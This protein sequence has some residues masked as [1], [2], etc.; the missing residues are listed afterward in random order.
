M[1]GRRRVLTGG[2]ALTAAPVRGMAATLPPDPRFEV[3]RD[4]IR[5]GHPAISFH[6]DGDTTVAAVEVEIVVRLGPIPVFRYTHSVRETWHGD[7][8]LS[9]E[10]DTYNDGTPYHVEAAN[11][12][13]H[14]I[15]A[16]RTVPHAELPPE[17]IPLTHWNQLRMR[18]P[19]F[20]P[21]DGVPV[22][23]TV[24]P[25]GEE[26][27]AMADGRAVRAM[28]YSLVGKIA[29]EDWY[30]AAGKWIALRSI[31]HDGSRI[32]YRLAV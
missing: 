17:T 23:S 22:E 18:R 4:D 16:T 26:M 27:V 15:V 31:G 3:F 29:L 12:G 2:A 6:A 13:D 9:L 25:R 20:N 32:E 5:I 1:F 10:S 21:Q 30:D 8:F 24:A 11:T 28:H 14:V 19:L 7:R